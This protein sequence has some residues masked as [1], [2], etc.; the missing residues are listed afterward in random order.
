[1]KGSWSIGTVADV[2]VRLHWS[3]AVVA[4]FLAS[5]LSSAVGVVPAV[6]GV[7]AFG[8]SIL[9]HEL[10]HALVARRSGVSTRS[11]ELWALGGMARLDREAPSPGAEAR[12]AVAGPFASLMLGGL[13]LALWYWLPQTG[14]VGE[15]G[16]VSGWLAVVNLGLGV[17]N[18]LPGAPLDGGRVVRA[19]RWAQHGDR[20]RAGREAGTAGVVLGWLVAG[21]GLWLLLRGYGTITVLLVGVFI[22]VNARVEIAAAELHSRV[23]GMRVGDLAWFG[24]AVFS[25]WD[26]AATVLSQRWRMGPSEV[27]SVVD[28]RGELLGVMTLEAAA[29]V[30][31]ERRFDVVAEDLMVPIEAVVRATPD[32]EL[33]DSLIGVDL[34]RPVITVWEA[35]RLVGVVPPSAMRTALGV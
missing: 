34:A 10:A 30:E 15:I 27:A 1:M 35:D 25:P 31:P 16:R 2:P 12:I 26:D 32:A 8:G 17:F 11:I 9:A 19:V 28:D 24:L 13:G 21:V 14:F 20:Y 29:A 7:L 5:G 4:V 18:M 6:L 33:S 23:A 3:V 22:A